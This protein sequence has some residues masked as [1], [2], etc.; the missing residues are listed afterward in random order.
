M[1]LTLACTVWSLHRHPLSFLLCSGW[2]ALLF[3]RRGGLA[4]PQA[5]ALQHA[6]HCLRLATWLLILASAFRTDWA[7]WS[8]VWAGAAAAAVSSQWRHDPVQALSFVAAVAS[9][10]FVLCGGPSVRALGSCVLFVLHYFFR[11]RTATGVRRHIRDL[12]ADGTCVLLLLQ[13]QGAGVWFVVKVATMLQVWVMLVVAIHMPVH[14][15]S[16]V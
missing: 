12:G 7:T 9:A 1:I 14:L 11:S 2:T 16:V 6:A 13:I 10:G 4:W 8:L 5:P 3:C 15:S